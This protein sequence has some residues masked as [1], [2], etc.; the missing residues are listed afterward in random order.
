MQPEAA[1]L[2]IHDLKNA[3]GALEAQLGQ[4]EAAPGVAAARRAHRD[5]RELRQRA[6]AFLTLYAL[7]RDLCAHC[8][9]ESP[10]ELLHTLA[11]RAPR[12]E[13][14]AAPVL[15]VDAGTPPF[16]FFDAHL[17]RLAL[18]AALHN[19]WRYARHEV[20]LGVRAGE[21]YLVFRVTD[22]GPGPDATHGDAHSTGLGSALCAA[23]ARVHG[24][25]GRP[26]RSQLSACP[27]GGAL[28]ELCLAT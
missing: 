16:A 14:A 17:V 5:C 13:G 20:R 28:F 4:L 1:A 21:G 22:D 9:D 25:P 23:V 2:V 8:D 12:P 24:Q 11:E 3:L 18:E 26:G 15:E 10:H 19:A 7:D 27:G 6:V